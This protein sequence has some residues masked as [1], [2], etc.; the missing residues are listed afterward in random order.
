MNKESTHKSIYCIVLFLGSTKTA[1]IVLPS[2]GFEVYIKAGRGQERG[3]W[4]TDN[5][6]FLNLGANRRCVPFMKINWV[7]VSQF[8][9]Y[10]ECI[11]YLKIKILKRKR[12]ISPSSISPHPSLANKVHFQGEQVTNPE[13]L[14]L[15]CHTHLSLGRRFLVSD[16]PIRLAHTPQCIPLSGTVKVFGCK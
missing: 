8:V 1:Q 5:V 7:V 2:V 9:H 15:K 16:Y 14:Y 11:L 4:G 13:N 3:F 6:L 10:S 12:K